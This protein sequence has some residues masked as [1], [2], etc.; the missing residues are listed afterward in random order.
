MGNEDQSRD[1]AHEQR[2][3]VE[4][5]DAQ[6]LP[7]AIQLSLARAD[8]ILA[9]IILFA[10]VYLATFFLLRSVIPLVQWVGLLSGVVATAVTLAIIERGRWALGFEQPLARGWQELLLGIGFGAILIAI[11]DLLLRLSVTAPRVRGD[12]FPWIELAAVYVPAAVHEELVFR[13]YVYQKIRSW[14]P[15]G[16]IAFTSLIFAALHAGNTGLT[17]LGLLNLTLGGV[18]LG[19][20]YEWRRRLWMPIGLHLAWNLMSGPV[21]GYAV[22]GYLSEGSIFITMPVGSSALAGGAFGLEGT[23][24]IS[25]AELLGIV[26][27]LQLN[28]RGLEENDASGKNADADRHVPSPAVVESGSTE[29][30]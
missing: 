3:D 29:K 20:A 14:R 16:A 7:R 19:L 21:L 27:V 6:S 11:S 9:P 22:S 13:G 23:V 24:W 8:R 28:R 2:R 18:L 26:A 10:A 12:G 25:V 30:R 5:S 17:P 4:S 15:G 1:S